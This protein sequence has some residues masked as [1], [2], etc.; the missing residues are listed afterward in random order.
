MIEHAETVVIHR[1][2]HEVWA[3]VSR[4]EAT[5]DWRT[6]VT[7][8]EPPDSLVV[9]AAFAATTKV[10]GRTW[11]WS[12]RLTEVENGRRL[13]Y[14]VTKGVVKP[15]VRYDLEPHE[16][17]TRFTFTGTVGAMGTAGR[18]LSMV[19][20]PTLRREIATHLGNLKRIVESA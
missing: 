4:L 5:P 14:V 6:T 20:V 19:A 12:M 2:P 7:S 13:G 11:K 9:G 18:L 3:Y 15:H 16:E 10:L 8:V 17:G 1:P